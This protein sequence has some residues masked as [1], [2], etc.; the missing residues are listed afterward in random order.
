MII[1]IFDT[2]TTGLPKFKEINM[3]ELDSW[4]YIVQ[5]S[6]ILFNT[7]TYEIIK[8]VDSVV[9]LVNPT[10]I[11][12]ENS[13]IHGITNEI[14]KIKGVNINII[15]KKFFKNIQNVDLIVAHNMS[16]DLN[17]I[18]VEL[19]RLIKKNEEN[20]TYSK[21]LSDLENYKKYYCTMQESIDLCNIIVQNKYNTNY[22]K[23]P[24]LV[25]LYEKLFE[26]TPK[27]LHNSLNDVLVTLKCF[28]KLKFNV[29]ICDYSKEIKELFIPL[30]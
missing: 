11:T 20:D 25:E 6:Y 2:E 5:F 22:V 19:L 3:K 18:K 1:A 17:M 24:K 23:F 12:E 7:E 26:K 10:E 8:I 29:D 9:K 4:P 14:S 30:L 21:L 27:N 16:F 15:L 13:N 28:M